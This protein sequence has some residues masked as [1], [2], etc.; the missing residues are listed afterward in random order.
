MT[1]DRRPRD[2]PQ[3]RLSRMLRIGGLASGIGGRALA[4]G[5]R[6]MASGQRPRAQDLLLTPANAA[7]LAAGLAQ[8]R[9]AAMKLGQLISMDAGEFLPP[10]LAQILSRL[11]ADAD[12]MPPKQLQRV[13]DAAW[14]EGWLRHFSRFQ[15]RPIAAASIGQVH[16]AQ[17]RDGRDLAIKVQYPGVRASINSDIANLGLLF[18]VPGALPPGL[19]LPSLLAEARLQLHAEADYVQEAAQMRRFGQL[20]A[21]RPEFLLPVPDD[22]F[23]TRDV[24]AMDFIDSRPIETLADAP[25]ALRDRVATDLV[26]LVIDELFAF[27]LMQTDPNFANFRWQPDSGRIVLL[28]FGATRGFSDPVAPRYLALLRAALAGDAEA[29]R[30]TA[31]N[32]G[33]FRADTD[34]D[35]QAML[36]QM[37]ETAFQP[38]RRGGVFDVASTDIPQRITEVAMQIARTRQR[39]EMPP[40]EVLFLHRKFGGLYLLLARLHARVDLDDLVDPGRL[41]AQLN[42]RSQASARQPPSP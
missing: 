4:E 5:A 20:L 7:R 13:L 26:R 23:C 36:L 19:D 9:G 29:I 41:E 17:T 10:E 14:G 31:V 32:I 8:M 18:R 15:V 30:R 37:M 1:D 2:V 22:Q 24:L 34:A 28:D 21:D 40:P 35:H 38:L 3:G 39:A 33:Y 42:A 6:Q 16:R 27:N 11:R 25:Q 12:P